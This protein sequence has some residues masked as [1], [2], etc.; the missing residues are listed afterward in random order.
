M[1]ARSVSLAA[2]PSFCKASL[3]RILKLDDRVAI[4]RLAT[5]KSTVREPL[6]EL[7]DPSLQKLG[8]AANETDLASI[9]SYLTGLEP[10]ARVRLLAAVVNA[11][12]KL[13][14]VTPAS[15]REAI[16]SSRDQAAALGVMLRADGVF[17]FPV[18]RDDLLLAKDG[19]INPR[20]LLARYPIAL[21][22]FAFV[23]LVLFMLLWR[24]LFGRRTRI[25]VRKS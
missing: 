2:R 6:L 5:L 17:D 10:P 7:D 14:M 19:K 3:A 12:G 11:P 9:S 20:I 25:V 15:V 13:A 21:S 8:R 18:F 24:L 23:G 16:L 4:S 22:I 1:L